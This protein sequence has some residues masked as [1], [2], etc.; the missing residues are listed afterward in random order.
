MNNISLVNLRDYHSI[1]NYFKSNEKTLKNHFSIINFLFCN[2][3]INQVLSR[4]VVLYGSGRFGRQV[5][6]VLRLIGVEPLCFASTFTKDNEQYVD[7]LKVLNINQL[8]QI[9]RDVIVLIASPSN[10]ASIK[11]QLLST[12]FSSSNIYFPLNVD[13]YTELYFGD[14]NYQVL[15][16]ISKF[17]NKGQSIEQMILKYSNLAEDLNGVFVDEVSKSLLWA[18]V[19]QT[20]FW[21]DI[22]IFSMF[23]RSFSEPIKIFGTR[24]FAE[25]GPENYFYFN[26]DIFNLKNDEVYI[27]IG[28]FDGDSINEFIESNK[29]RNL[30]FRKII[31]F[32]PDPI[33][34][35]RLKNNINN[36]KHITLENLGVSDKSGSA[37]FISSLNSTS[38]SGSNISSDGD[39]EVN[40]VSLD[41]YLNEDKVSIIKMDPPGETISYKI[42]DGAT[43]T[44]LKHKP[45]IIIGIHSLK[46]LYDLINKINSSFHFYHLYI[47]H[48]SWGSG[49]VDLYLIPEP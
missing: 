5:N 19:V 38:P 26:N 20:I 10:A 7:G 43:R 16:S 33:N 27:D 18:I 15:L 11:K 23:M 44:I 49:E 46:E 4:E 2:L 21:D 9:K 34:Y 36:A 29:V 42:L 14:A 8:E 45:K 24:P 12:G 22:G 17:P 37:R 30:S 48:N 39:I 35:S 40:L 6:R 1:L 41:V 47:R 3:T 13:P 28:A 31:A 25:N 32:E